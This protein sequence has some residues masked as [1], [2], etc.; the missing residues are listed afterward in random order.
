MCVLDSSVQCV[1]DTYPGYSAIWTQQER[2]ITQ[3]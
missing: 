3:P 2:N 1:L